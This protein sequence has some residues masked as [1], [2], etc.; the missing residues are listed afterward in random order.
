M[1][2][3]EIGGVKVSEDQ[4]KAL[5]AGYPQ[6]VRAQLVDEGDGTATLLAETHKP[7]LGLAPG[8]RAA[9]GDLG[10]AVRVLFVNDG[11]L[12]EGAPL[13]AKKA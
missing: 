9:V 1:A 13:V 10:I 12:P 8:L 11:T 7:S 3:I 5:L 6:V 2:E 4:V